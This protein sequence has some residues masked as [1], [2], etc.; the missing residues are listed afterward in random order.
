MNKHLILDIDNTLIHFYHKQLPVLDHVKIKGGITI[1]RRPWMLEFLNWA[2]LHFASVSLWTNGNKGWLDIFTNEVAPGYSWG[3]TWDCTHSEKVYHKGMKVLCKPLYKVWSQF[4]G[5]SPENTII[6]DDTIDN[7]IFNYGN[8]I[9]IRPWIFTDRGNMDLWYLQEY[10]SS[11]LSCD[12]VREVDK[13]DWLVSSII[14]TKLYGRVSVR[15][16]QQV[17]LKKYEKDV[18]SMI[19]RSLF[20]DGII[21]IHKV[22]DFFRQVNDLVEE[23]RLG[24][25]YKLAKQFEFPEDHSWRAT[26][27]VAL[28]TIDSTS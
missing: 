22:D 11:I 4:P 21:S 9:A 27:N 6:V 15:E 1:Y 19:V 20:R 17:F 26:I 7:A 12:D 10:L 8:S 16:S 25:L 5:M 18:V 23:E 14:Q 24:D 2:H 13:R 3:F 28:Q